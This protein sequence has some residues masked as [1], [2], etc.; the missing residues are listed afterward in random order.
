MPETRVWA[1]PAPSRA[2]VELPRKRAPRLSRVWARQ[3]E[4]FRPGE[5]VFTASLTV[6][7]ALGRYTLPEA[8][9]AR[10]RGAIL[11]DNAARAL[12]RLD[13]ASAQSRAAES[14]DILL[15]SL[16][17]YPTLVDAVLVAGAGH[18]SPAVAAQMVAINA[19]A[20]ALTTMLTVLAKSVAARER[21]FGRE[22]DGQGAAGGRCQDANR[23]KSFFSGH[24]ATAFTGA[25]LVCAHHQA[26]PLYGGGVA[27]SS[28]C[29]LSL[30][31]ASTVGVLR[32][33]ADKHY[34]TDVL[35][36]AGVGLL[37]G[38]FL[39]R[40]LHYKQQQRLHRVLGGGLIVPLA[41]STGAIGLSY[42]HAL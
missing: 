24:A 19:Q 42:V 37:S 20:F 31:A 14:S 13:T 33:M 36:G 25:G 27:D 21:P 10:W 29:A 4:G 26:L 23:Y 7:M 17:A 32:M 2:S 35:L 40:I 5:Y 22:C 28:A 34:S 11:T 9:Q 18:Q 15:Y 38:Y 39:P 8:E 12:F 16:I 3:A 1:E 30:A 6:G 41:S